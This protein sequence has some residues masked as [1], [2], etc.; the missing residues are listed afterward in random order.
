MDTLGNLWTTHPIQTGWEFTIEPYPSW[1][2]GFIDN[3]DD[4]FG[5]GSVWTGT[6]TQSDGP[7]QLVTIV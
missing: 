1:W 6:R 3:S 7:E 5:S 4:Q 2:F